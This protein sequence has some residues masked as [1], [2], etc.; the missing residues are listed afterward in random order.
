MDRKEYRASA[1]RQAQPVSKDVRIL[2]WRTNGYA[3]KWR[4]L[5]FIVAD[6]VHAGFFWRHVSVSRRDRGMPSYEDLK[7]AKELTIGD[8]RAAIQVFPQTDKH[9]DYS[10]EV[11]CEV[12]HLWSPEDNSVLPDFRL[13]GTI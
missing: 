1:G 8:D 10:N 13:A 4:H 2:H 9:I 5:T 3:G 7:K 11:E 6:E 12:L